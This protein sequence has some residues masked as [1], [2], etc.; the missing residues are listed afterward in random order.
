MLA[1]LHKLYFMILYEGTRKQV[2]DISFIEEFQWQMKVIHHEYSVEEEI[3]RI[4]N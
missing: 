4:E 1:L 3:E 2:I